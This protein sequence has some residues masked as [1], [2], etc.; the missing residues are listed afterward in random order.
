MIA[1]QTGL[2]S[3]KICLTNVQENKINLK[4]ITIQYELGVVGGSMKEVTILSA[5]EM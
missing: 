4:P 2:N 3:K 5:Q 1:I